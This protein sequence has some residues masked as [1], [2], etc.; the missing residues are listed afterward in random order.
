MSKFEGDKNN[1][2]KIFV[3]GFIPRTSERDIYQHFG[4]YGRI[5]NVQII[6]DKVTGCSRGYAFVEYLH[7]DDA[8]RAYCEANK[9]VMDNGSRDINVDVVRSGGK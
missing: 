5:E 9:S 6:R 8:F 7:T 2:R 3:S 4:K 1:K